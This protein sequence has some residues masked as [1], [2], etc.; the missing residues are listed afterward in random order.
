MS[1]EAGEAYR[2][3]IVG[4]APKGLRDV[5]V[6]GEVTEQA[7]PKRKRKRK[8]VV[9]TGED[10]DAVREPFTKP[11]VLEESDPKQK[12]DNSTIMYAVMGIGAFLGILFLSNKA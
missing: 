1:V 10:G 9:D 3:S 4:M 2:K 12:E 6:P 8:R 7:G 5:T 11:K